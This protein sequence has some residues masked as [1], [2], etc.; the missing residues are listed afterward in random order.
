MNEEP[1]LLRSLLFVPGNKENMLAKALGTRP[2]AIVPDM[3][4]SVPDAEKDAA[5]ETIRAF[6]PRLAASPALVI[7]RVNAPGTPWHERDVEAVVVPGVYAVTVGKVRSPADIAAVSGLIADLERRRG[8]PV[9][10]VRLLPWIETAAGLAAAAE[11]L[12]SDP[13]IVAAAFGAEDFTHDL[14]I[15]RDLDDETQLDT[16]RW[17]LSIAAR[18]AGVIALDTPHFKLR[19]PEGLRASARRVRRIGFRGKFAIHPEQIDALNACF[20]PSD[21]EIAEARRIVAAFDEA[22]RAGRAST[23][24]DGRVIDVPVVKR[25]RAVLEAAETHARSLQ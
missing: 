3:E 24:L 23:S 19:D 17:L 22:E 11:I 4:D 7:P 13:R 14:G 2:D 18:A 16:P 21:D 5:R 12:A 9:G 20:S 1:P 8:L 25:A 6:L 15:E 10:T